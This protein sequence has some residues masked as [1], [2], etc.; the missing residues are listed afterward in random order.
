MKNKNENYFGHI[1]YNLYFCNFKFWKMKRVIIIA[2][3]SVMCGFA[4]AQN[5]YSRFYDAVQEGD[6]AG[7]ANAIGEIIGTYPRISA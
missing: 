7:M 1:R 4:T 6:S 5:A 3:L 2:L